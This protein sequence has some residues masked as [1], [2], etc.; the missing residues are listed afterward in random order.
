L[1]DYPS[2]IFATVACYPFTSLILS[3]IISSTLTLSMAKDRI[4]NMAI[5]RGHIWKEEPYQEKG[6]MM[7][8]KL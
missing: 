2:H 8:A 1:L 5:K 6:S 4:Y 3:F 7:L